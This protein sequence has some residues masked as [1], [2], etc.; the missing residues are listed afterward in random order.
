PTA[1]FAATDLQA[2]GV[3]NKARALGLRVPEDLA[4]L[5]FD[6]LDIAGYVGL[7]TIRQSL[8]ESGRLA[9]EILLSRIKDPDRPLRHVRLP[10][11]IIERQT[12]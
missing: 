7:S 1:I 4:V 6:D 5:G 2:L 11:K 10:L 8:E 3:V 12:T 9:V